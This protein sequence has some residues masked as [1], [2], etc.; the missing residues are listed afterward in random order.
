MS[1]TRNTSTSGCFTSLRDPSARCFISDAVFLGR[2]FLDVVAIILLFVTFFA[3]GFLVF[4]SSLSIALALALAVESSYKARKSAIRPSSIESL[5]PL[6]ILASVDFYLLIFKLSPTKT[7][8][9]RPSAAH[10]RPLFPPGLYTLPSASFTRTLL[11]PPRF[12]KRLS[13]QSL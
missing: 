4:G 12:R 2:F 11:T 8:P 7:S 1:V 13:N 3:G 5:S 9:H 10:F 6:A